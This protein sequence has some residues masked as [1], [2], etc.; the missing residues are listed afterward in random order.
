[1]LLLSI[2]VKFKSNSFFISDYKLN[3]IS[4]TTHQRSADS[5]LHLC[6][7]NLG[8]YVKIGQHVGAM[9]FLLPKEYVQTL[10][11]LFMNAPVSNLSDV[12]TVIKEDLGNSIDELFSEFEKTPLGSASLAQCHKAR[13]RSTGQIVAVKVQHKRV[14][15]SAHKDVKIM[16]LGIEIADK[17]FPEFKLKWLPKLTKENLFRELDFRVEYEN[18]IK[19]QRLYKGYNW[20]I[21]PNAYKDLTSERVITMDYVDGTYVDKLP[22]DYSQK[23][24]QQIIHRLQELYFDMMFF[25]GFVHCDPHP[26]NLLVTKDDRIVLIDH[27]LYQTFSE[28][29]QYNF[30]SLWLSIIK[31]DHSKI[32]KY[33]RRLGVENEMMLS[34]MDS[35]DKLVIIYFFDKKSLL[36]WVQF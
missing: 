23:K 21:I 35:F 13:L 30:T 19:A 32:K 7:L 25:K 24:K 12:E 4:S 11:T 10:K 26:G 1:M 17:I 6:Y 20:L 28:S 16:E 2:K 29:V 14:L 31:A 8:T 5:L 15:Q 36:Q 18:T 22:D 34:S 3:G 9:D 33:A 27:G